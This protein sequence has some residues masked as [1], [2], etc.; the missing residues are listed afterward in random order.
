MKIFQALAALV[1]I[2]IS[3][4]P[5]T[6]R[7]QDALRAWNAVPKAIRDCVDV[8]AQRANISLA[9][10]IASGV[11]PSDQRLADTMAI[12]KQFVEGLKENYRCTLKLPNNESINTTCSQ[13]Y[14]YRDGNQFKKI[15]KEEAFRDAFT[16]RSARNLIFEEETT[17]GRR[18]REDGIRQS[19][20]GQSSSND[21]LLPVRPANPEAGPT[22]S[23]SSLPS[24]EV[25]HVVVRVA[26]SEGYWYLLEDGQPSK[27]CAEINSQK[28]TFYRFSGATIARSI[29]LMPGMYTASSQSTEFFVRDN[30]IFYPRRAKDCTFY[31]HLWFEKD[32][33]DVLLQKMTVSANECSSERIA[34]LKRVRLVKD[35]PDQFRFCVGEPVLRGINTDDIGK[36]L[37]R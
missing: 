29:Y 34:F 2:A 25:S 33:P 31:T 22:T 20:E 36:N 9:G 21:R 8:A 19:L 10:V 15:T 16:Q 6:T 37:P 5:G 28:A 27:Q 4:V 18:F 23:S 32:N 26:R 7:A 12:C 17:E 14:G 24:T 30:E 11:M 35:E 1:V 3:N 13:Y